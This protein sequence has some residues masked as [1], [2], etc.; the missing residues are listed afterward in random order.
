MPS[1]ASTS[2]SPVTPDPPV[3]TT[4]AQRSRAAAFAGCGRG[5]RRGRRRHIRAGR[6]DFSHRPPFLMPPGAILTEGASRRAPLR[7]SG[8]RRTRPFG[9]RQR[10]GRR[11]EP[12]RLRH[13]LPSQRRREEKA[14][15]GVPRGRRV[16]DGHVVHPVGEPRFPLPVEDAALPQRQHDTGAGEPREHLRQDFQG[17]LPA[18]DLRALHLVEEEDIHLPKVAREHPLVEGRGVERNGHPPLMRAV[19]QVVHEIYLILQQEQVPRA[20]IREH[21]VRVFPRDRAV[22]AGIEHDAVLSLR[23]HLDD[24]VAGAG[25]GGAHAAHIHA[26]LPA[27]VE[28]HA[29]VLSHHARVADLGRPRARA[30]PTG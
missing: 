30:P 24:R 25:S 16:H 3:I 27:D 17:V 10:G 7:S 15:E 20:E 19:D 11:R 2:R 14:G 22:R 18:G 13:R 6:W 29:A 9:Y 1:R 5:R 8:S 21:P 23:A 12:Q 28:Q 4:P 26:R